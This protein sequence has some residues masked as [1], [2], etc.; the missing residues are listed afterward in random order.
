MTLFMSLLPFSQCFVS[1]LF[2]CCFF[3]SEESNS[4]ARK[5]NKTFTFTP[6]EEGRVAKRVVNFEW[7]SG[8]WI[9]LYIFFFYTFSSSLT[10][11]CKGFISIYLFAFVYFS[12][13]LQVNFCRYSSRLVYLSLLCSLISLKQSSLVFSK[14]SK[15]TGEPSFT[16][17]SLA[18]GNLLASPGC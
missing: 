9:L 18:S 7:R 5:L 14:V 11:S 4:G 16:F 2:C 13:F 10:T 1:P 17:S 6:L 15:R 8:L 12:Y 3:R